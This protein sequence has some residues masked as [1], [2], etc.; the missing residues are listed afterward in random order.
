MHRNRP[1]GLPSPRAHGGVAQRAA[2]LR[3]DGGDLGAFVGDGYGVFR[4]VAPGGVGGAEDPAVV[5]DDGSGV[6]CWGSG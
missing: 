1:V 6:Q 3:Q 4:V 2:G 5:V